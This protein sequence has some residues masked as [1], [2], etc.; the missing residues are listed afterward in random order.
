MKDV[1]NN[2]NIE[3]ISLIFEEERKY[4]QFAGLA[5]TTKFPT[6]SPTKSFSRK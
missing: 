3:K 5:I 2:Q 1:F 4:V 6:K